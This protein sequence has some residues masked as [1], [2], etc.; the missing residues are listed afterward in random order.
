MADCLFCRIVAGDGAGRHGRRDRRTLAFRDINPPAPVHVLVVPRA[1]IVNA[2]RGRPTTDAD[3]SSA[4]L[5]AAREVAEAEGIAGEDRGYRLVVQRRARRR[6]LGAAPPPPRA[7]RPVDGV[8]A[9]MSAAGERNRRAGRRG[10]GR[11]PRPRRWSRTTTSWPAC[12]A[13]ATSCCAWSRGR[14]PRPGIAVRATGS[15]SRAPRP[16]GW[17]GS[18]TS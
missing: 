18:S 6:Q 16:S 12:S 10:A 13:S 17:R 4:L 7:R 9:R 1:H 2:A 14:S 8:A 11:R 15:P 3:D 5:V